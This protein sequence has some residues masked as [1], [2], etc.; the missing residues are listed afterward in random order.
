LGGDPWDGM[1]KDEAREMI[2]ELQRAKFK[3]KQAKVEGKTE[4]RPLTQ[5]EIEKMGDALF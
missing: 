3:Q 2:D 4:N 5:A 1:T